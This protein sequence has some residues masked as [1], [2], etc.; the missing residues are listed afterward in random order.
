MKPRAPLCGWQAIG[1]PGKTTPRWFI[2]VLVATVTS[3]CVSFISVGEAVYWW[4]LGDMQGLFKVHGKC[5]VWKSCAWISKIFASEVNLSFNS[6]SP[7]T[8]QAASNLESIYINLLAENLYKLLFMIWVP[9]D[10]GPIIGKCHK[11]I[12]AHFAFYTLLNLYSLC[13]S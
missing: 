10:L 12:T 11:Y 2:S 9:H 1:T 6:I 8:F 7:G 3:S 5:I 4:P 13:L